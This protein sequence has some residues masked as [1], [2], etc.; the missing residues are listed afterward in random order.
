[1]GVTGSNSY[2]K[3]SQ[4]T[5]QILQTG[6]SL[7]TSMLFCFNIVNELSLF[8]YFMKQFECY[9]HHDFD[10]ITDHCYKTLNTYETFK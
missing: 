4:E 7:L 1:M 2:M 6:H 5:G 10:L 3:Y 9:H 8:I